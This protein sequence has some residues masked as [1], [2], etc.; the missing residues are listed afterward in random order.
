MY[1]LQSWA[2]HSWRGD[3]C[4]HSR[5]LHSRLTLSD[6][7]ICAATASL[8]DLKT[9]FIVPVDLNS[10]LYWNGR[11]LSEFHTLLGNSEKA[12]TY[13]EQAETLHNNIQNVLW[14][15]EAGSWFDYD[16]KNRV[17]SNTDRRRHWQLFP[18]L[19]FISFFFF[20]FYDENTFG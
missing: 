16:T 11:L 1:Y 14:D 3:Y 9:R 2:V 12:A 5:L 18:H 6:P 20:K 10:L 15:Q 4:P 8:K 7:G 19:A 17:R 13:H